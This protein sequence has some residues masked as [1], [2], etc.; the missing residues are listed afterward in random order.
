MGRCG[1]CQVRLLEADVEGLRGKHD[2]E[3]AWWGCFL[4]EQERP[5]QPRHQS[6]FIVQ[7]IFSSHNKTQPVFEIVYIVLFAFA[8]CPSQECS[9]YT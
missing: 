5:G 3:H 8:S 7:S 2:F 9:T 1:E 4:L 6:L